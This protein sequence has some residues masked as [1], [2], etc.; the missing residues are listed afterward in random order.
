MKRP[1]KYPAQ[2]DKITLVREIKKLTKSAANG[3]LTMCA[4]YRNELLTPASINTQMAIERT[5]TTGLG[6][7]VLS[8]RLW[9][10]QKALSPCSA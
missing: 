7:V 9:V 10:V 8:I 2:T 5:D 4:L 3:P 6:W 1:M